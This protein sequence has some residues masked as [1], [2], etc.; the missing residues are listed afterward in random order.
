MEVYLQSILTSALE[1]AWNISSIQAALISMV[2][3]I[4][5]FIGDPVW[6]WYSDV[7]GRK[8]AVF[9]S[10]LWTFVYAL[11]S[12]TSPS[13]FWIVF[14]R[15][16]TGFGISGAIQVVTIYCE[17]LPEIYRCLSILVLA[18][19]WSIGGC[20]TN[21][22]AMLVMPTLDWRYVLGFA[23]IPCLAFCLLYKFVP[24]SPRFYLVS[25]QRNKTLK[26]LADG[27]KANGV[28]LLEGDLIVPEKD[29][30]GQIRTLFKKQHRKTTILLF[31]IWS[32]A[33]F[34][35]FGMI[36]L[37]PLLL[38]NQNCGNDNTV[39]NTISD[40]SCKPLTTKHYQ[41]LI[42]TAFA[43]IPGLIVSFIIIQLLGRRKGIA[44]QFFLAGIPIPFLI[45]CTSSATKTILLSC[46]RAFSNAVFQTII[47]YT[48]EVYPTSIRAIGLGMCSAANRFGVFI[49]PLVAQ[50]IFPKSNLAGLLIY[51]ILCL[52]SGILAL[53]LPIETR[54][55]LL[56]FVCMLILIRRRQ[57]PAQNEAELQD[58]LYREAIVILLRY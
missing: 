10:T 2:S 13:F 21:L 57:T 3:F 12:A 43:E 35:Y 50:V 19:F 37:S 33:G 41:Y 55:R 54:G 11:L 28:S 46:T 5:M 30:L 4:G 45:A 9:Y 17:F 8:M 18:V 31:L 16:L 42:A 6:G 22:I 15:G 53:T 51:T 36:L 48:A 56:Q 49:S 39:R 7:Y 47:L 23:S 34:C 27:A 32:S 25:G 44:L 52:S 38:V 14:T 24:E 58:P 20:L 1:C 29:S 26:V 40:C